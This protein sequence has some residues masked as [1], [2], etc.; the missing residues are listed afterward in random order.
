MIITEGFGDDQTLITEGFSWSGVGVGPFHA[1]AA[2]VFV[3]GATAA[4]VHIAGSKA[5]E[6]FVPGAQAAKVYP[7]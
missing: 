1:V 2:E 3:P 4:A 5:A 6:V 7:S